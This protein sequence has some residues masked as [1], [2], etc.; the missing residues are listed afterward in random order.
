MPTTSAGVI[1]PFRNSMMRTSSEG[2]SSAALIQPSW[3]VEASTEEPR[4]A[5]FVIAAEPA[6]LLDWAYV[7]L[8]YSIARNEPIGS[9]DECSR[10]F[11][12]VN[13]RKKYC[14]ERCATRVRQREFLSQAPRWPCRR[15]RRPALTAEGR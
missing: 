14:G 10:P 5:E 1:W 12:R 4:W 13:Q 3:T 8:A 2:I 6:T 7:E 15:P 9:C 11:P